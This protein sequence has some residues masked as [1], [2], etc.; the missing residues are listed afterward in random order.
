MKKLL[1]ATALLALAAPAFLHAQ[2]TSGHWDEIV[3]KTVVNSEGE[4]LGT[5]VDSVVDLENGRYLGMVVSTGGFLGL[6]AKKIIVPPSA[7]QDRGIPH[8]LHLDMAVEKF[9]SA[10]VYE[11]PKTVGPPDSAKVA[12]VFQFFGQK[13]PFAVRNERT[14]SNAAPLG[15]L[16]KTSG[17]LFM[18]V[19]NLQ[20]VGVGFVKGLRGLNRVTQRFE[21]VVIDSLNSDGQMKIVPPQS[22]RYSLTHDRLRI[23]DH[24]QPFRESANFSLSPTGAF[25]E[26]NPSRPGILPPPLVHGESP[27]DKAISLAIDNRILA[28]RQLTI[29]GKNI[30]VATLNGKTTLRGRVTTEANRDRIISYAKQIAGAQNVTAQLE[31]RPMSEQEK[32]IDR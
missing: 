4:K 24:A 9:R 25:T 22:L 18:P 7:L 6:G 8:R 1:I 11:L 28:D 10:P 30:E 16:R 19:E 5:V 26:E 17:I 23:N 32:A 20:G 27:A 15:Y 13:P 3:G 14:A 12:E 31:V 2:A 21:G 29:Y